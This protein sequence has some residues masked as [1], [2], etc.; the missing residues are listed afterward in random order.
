MLN[1]SEDHLNRFENRMENYVAA[2]WPAFENQRPEDFAVLNYDDPVVRDM[3][4]LTKA[5][6]VLFSQARRWGKA[7]AYRTGV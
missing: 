2:K 5:R 3:A 1:I 7:C 4:R 6:V